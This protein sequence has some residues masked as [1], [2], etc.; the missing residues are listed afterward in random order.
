MGPL[1][2]QEN[3]YRAASAAAAA[4]S[5][6]GGVRDVASLLS[7]SFLTSVRRQVITAVA[8]VTAKA[9]AAVARE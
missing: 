4:V 7:I 5:S 8:A 2:W 1:Q 9:S 6:Q 3:T